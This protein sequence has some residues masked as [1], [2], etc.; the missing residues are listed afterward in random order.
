MGKTPTYILI[1][2]FFIYSFSVL[3]PQ[4]NTIKNENWIVTIQNFTMENGLPSN[5]VHKGFQDDRGFLW[6]LTRYGLVRFD[7]E[8]FKILSR[9]ENKLR[10]MN[11]YIPQ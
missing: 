10:V 6:F 4:K 2:F 7:G 8:E 9:T 5:T 1:V 11:S 3:Y